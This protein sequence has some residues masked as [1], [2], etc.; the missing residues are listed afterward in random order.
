[1]GRVLAIV[2][3][4]VAA[5][6]AGCGQDEVAARTAQATSGAAVSEP[7]LGPYLL[8]HGRA[9]ASLRVTD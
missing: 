2:S 3:F 4:I 9:R 1:M 8:A 7:G 5:F 6:T